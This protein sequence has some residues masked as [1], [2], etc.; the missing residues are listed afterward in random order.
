[1]KKLTKRGTCLRF[2]ENV[3]AWGIPLSPVPNHLLIVI[4]VDIL[5]HIAVVV[6]LAKFY[7]ISTKLKPLGF[8]LEFGLIRLVGREGP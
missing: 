8:I 1:M 6:R 2:H 5:V 4:W 7:N 3:Q